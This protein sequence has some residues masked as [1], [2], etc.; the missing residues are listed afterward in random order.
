MKTILTKEGLNKIQDEL[1]FLLTTETSRLLGEVRDAKDRGGVSEN[2]EYDAARE[3]YERLQV[4]ISKLQEM[5]DGAI[6]VSKLNV[7]CSKVSM[8]T[9]VK[10]FNNKVKKEMSFTIVPETDI[11]TKSGKISQNSPI[12]SALINRVVGDEVRLVV[13][14]GELLLKI[15][16]ISLQ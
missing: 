11:D 14:A 8:F 7:D 15:I 1:R 2:V 13:P 5:I 10:V 6:I 9:T 3:Q 16:D 12:G 4:K